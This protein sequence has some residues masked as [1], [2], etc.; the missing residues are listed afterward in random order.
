MTS[1]ENKRKGYEFDKRTKDQAITAWHRDNPGREKEELDVDHILP[2]FRAI[3][4]GLHPHEVNTLQN[5]RVMPRSEHQQR[6]HHEDVSE[7][8]EKLAGFVGRLFD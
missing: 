8:V 1:A 3:E 6:D 7:H 5:A 4:I 2:I